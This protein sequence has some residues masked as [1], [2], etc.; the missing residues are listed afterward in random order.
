MTATVGWP[1]F[2]CST[3][4]KTCAV[5]DDSMDFAV[6]DSLS[7]AEESVSSSLGLSAGELKSLKALVE[8]LGITTVS[9]SYSGI[10][11]PGTSVMM[12]LATL[13]CV[14]GIATKDKHPR[15]LWAVEIEESCRTEL[16]SHPCKGDCIFGDI[17]GFLTP[18]MQ[19][20]MRD[21]HAKDKLYTV[22]MPL[23]RNN[24]R[25]ALQMLPRA[26]SN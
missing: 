7:P 4:A 16:Q 20:E 15:H 9:T 10:D 26:T 19:N 6:P 17:T 18:R 5:R 3:Y 12:M 11:A 14:F 25:N 24:A 21:L 22:F 8:R 23:L 1:G 13:E 2:F